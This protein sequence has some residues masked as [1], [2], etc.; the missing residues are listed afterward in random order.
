MLVHQK[1]CFTQ[2]DAQRALEKAITLIPNY[3]EIQRFESLE[4]WLVPE[5][6]NLVLMEGWKISPHDDRGQFWQ[7][8]L[9]LRN[10]QNKWSIRG[11]AQKVRL[12]DPQCPGTFLIL[13]VGKSH[14]VSGRSQKPWALLCWNP[15]A[16]GFPCNPGLSDVYWQL[17]LPRPERSF[18]FIF[19]FQSLV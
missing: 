17:K 1:Y 8:A 14:C 9:V 6:D 18:I 7:P 2:S 4:T 11:S 12:I 5:V 19:K 3:K 16:S 15:K 13:D 10:D